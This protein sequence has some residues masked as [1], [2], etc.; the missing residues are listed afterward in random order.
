L[1]VLDFSGT[2][3]GFFFAS[4]ALLVKERLTIPT[5]ARRAMLAVMIFVS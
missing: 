1:A 4:C 3:H 2:T 5:I